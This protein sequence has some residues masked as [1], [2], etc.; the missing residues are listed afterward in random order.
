M[1]RS[2]GEAVRVGGCRTP[3]H[4][5]TTR[6]LLHDSRSRSLNLTSPLWGGRRQASRARRRA[7]WGAAVEDRNNVFDG[8]VEVLQHVHIPKTQNA[9]SLAGQQPISYFVP[10]LV[11]WIAVLSAIELDH[12]TAR[13]LDEVQNVGPERRLTPEVEAYCPQQAQPI[14]E[15]AFDVG[16]VCTQKPCVSDGAWFGSG[17]NDP[18]P[19]RSA[20][21]FALRRIDLPTRGR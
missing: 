9:I 17:S 19:T 14:P 2:D 15:L 5:R 13:V 6:H 10:N 4:H 21:R 1:G 16:C 12:D 8:A 7:G 18:P 3:A 11:R 20:S